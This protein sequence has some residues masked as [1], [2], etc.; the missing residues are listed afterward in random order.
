MSRPASLR[1]PAAVSFRD[2]EAVFVADRGGRGTLV[3][4]EQRYDFERQQ[5]MRDV[6]GAGFVLKTED[7]ARVL[8]ATFNDL[9]D[10]RMIW[11]GGTAYILREGASHQRGL[12]ER[13]SSR[14]RR[15]KSAIRTNKAFTSTQ[16]SLD[17]LE[18][19]TRFAEIKRLS[20]A[21]EHDTSLQTHLA[22]VTTQRILANSQLIGQLEFE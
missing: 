7:G 21:A 6:L 18:L 19:Q 16:R 4:A 15:S 10:G 17:K 3:V 9:R 11:L 12:P 22:G 5:T 8:D 14:P 20:L 2:S 13:R 1:R